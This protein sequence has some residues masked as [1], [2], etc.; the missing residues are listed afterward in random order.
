MTASPD[1]S[2]AMTQITLDRETF[3][4]YRA[5]GPAE[6]LSPDGE[7]FATLTP[8]VSGPTPDLA[9]HGWTAEEIAAAKARARSGEP[10]RPAEDVYRDVFGEDWRTRYGVGGGES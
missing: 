7:P 10:G 6:L 5:A 9:A 1:P 4:R 2:A 3:E 8:L